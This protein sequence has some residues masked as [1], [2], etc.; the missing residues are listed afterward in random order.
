MPF[1]S[2]AQQRYMYAKHP[3]IA[4]EFSAATPNFKKLPEHVKD[5]KTNPKELQMKH[6]KHHE[7]HKKEA[8]KKDGHKKHHE[9]TASKEIHH[10]HKEMHKHHM[11]ELS[12]HE[13]MMK[14]HEHHAKK[15]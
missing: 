10:H 7:E 15:K 1:K 11:K 8:H 3:E 9:H 13:K 4:E 2:K 5:K 14:K 12:H 6:E